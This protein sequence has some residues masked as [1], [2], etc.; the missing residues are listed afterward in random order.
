MEQGDGLMRVLHIFTNPHLTNGA[1]VFEYRIS[2]FLKDENIF[3]DYLVTEQASDDE[4]M[5][6][7]KMGSRVYKLPIDNNH[8]LLL[9]ELKINIQY[10]KFFKIGKSIKITRFRTFYKIVL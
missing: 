4:L 1:T 6:Y 2:E 9:R 3:F 7:K 10:F 8:G 5:R